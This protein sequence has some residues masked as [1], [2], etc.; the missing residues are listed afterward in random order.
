M[1][2]N[3]NAYA[4]RGFTLV[5]LLVVIVIIAALAGLT[6]PMVM[7]NQKKGASTEALNNAR[8]L[9]LGLFAFDVEYGTYPD[10]NTAD[11]I[12]RERESQL[13][14]SG[15]YSNDYFRQLIAAGVVNSEE[16]FYAKTKNSPRKPDNVMSTGEAL[17]PGEVGFGYLMNGQD[18]F[19]SS[20]SPS[21]P[22]AVAP[23][24]NNSASGEFDSDTY[25]EKAVVLRLDGS[26]SLV[27]I[28]PTSKQISIG[29]GTLLETGP[30]SVWGTDV[31]PTIRVPE[32]R[33][34]N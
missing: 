32:T 34:G 7:K 13:S 15:N 31:N 9:F 26:A 4:R 25:D 19:S 20:G 8:Q 22:I 16:P 24:L 5:E 28:R 27:D 3:I 14:L 18:A 21:R 6:A 33:G 1:K 30:N 11:I 29:S 23:L 12:R 17:K 10:S 2:T